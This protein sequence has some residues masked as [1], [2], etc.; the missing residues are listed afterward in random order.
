EAAGVANVGLRLAGLSREVAA[1]VIRLADAL[2]V[3]VE[4]GGVEG[5]VEE[6]LQDDGARNADGFGVD[7]R[8][9]QRAAGQVVVAV[10]LDLADLDR[11]AFLNIEGDADR[12][13][14]DRLDLG[15][16]G[17]ELVAVLGEQVLEDG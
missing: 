9:A 4:L 10:E 8:L 17:R 2:G 3:F 1:L 11:R 15:A 16:D 14:W 6:A 13:G 5:A 7:H 12:R